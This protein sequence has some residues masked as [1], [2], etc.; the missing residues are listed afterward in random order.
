MR[1]R[2]VDLDA[3]HQAHEL[4]P[5]AQVRLPPGEVLSQSLGGNG[6]HDDLGVGDGGDV[7]SGGAQALGQDALTEVALIGV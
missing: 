7:I 2:G 3:L 4:D 6:E 1:L 5:G